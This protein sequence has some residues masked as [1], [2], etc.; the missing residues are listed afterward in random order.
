MDLGDLHTFTRVVEL[1]S[2]SGAAR[3]S[4]VPV[5]QISRALARLEAKHKVR[6]LHRS[7]HALSLTEAG[8]SLLEHG[9]RILD[10]YAQFEADVGDHGQVGGVVKLA[11]SPAMAHYVI[12]PSLDALAEQHPRLSV[13]LHVDDRV[14]DLAQHGIDLAI[15]S[16]DPGSD[17]LVARKIG[18]LGRRLYASPQYLAKHGMPTSV[19]DLQHHRLIT[20]SVH[21][22]YNRWPFMIGSE[23]HVH[24]ARGHYRA[25]STG[26]MMGMAL[27]SLGIVRAGNVAAEPMV[28]A[29]RLVRVM[30][31]QVDCQTM[32]IN[33]VMLQERHRAPKIRAC[34][35]FFAQWLAQH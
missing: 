28:A 24:V 1:G 33:A 14:V 6:L 30:D 21:P 19:D 15:R 32:P 9:K 3:E 22:A 25:N 18:E 5:S 17:T 29:G 12:V 26:I 34:I 23:A 10:N 2:L 20:S 7:T 27:Q 16:G 31:A 8:Q 35:D 4:D 13:E 11:V